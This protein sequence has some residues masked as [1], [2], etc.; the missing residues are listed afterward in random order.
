MPTMP[1]QQRQARLAALQRIDDFLLDLH[2]QSLQ[3][4][5]EQSTKTLEFEQEQQKR[6]E[7]IAYLRAARPFWERTS[8]KGP[9]DESNEE[10]LKAT[11]AEISQLER[12]E[13]EHRHA[14]AKYYSTVKVKKE[15]LL[16]ATE[17]AMNKRRTL[18]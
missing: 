12:E 3:L 17:A 7:R 1:S 6:Q 11:D 18:E 16:N 15:H 4:D 14:M 9:N 2:H 13:E 8:Q 10:M 5:N